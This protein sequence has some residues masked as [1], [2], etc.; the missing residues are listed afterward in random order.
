[1]RAERP[2]LWRTDG[3]NGRA[4]FRLIGSL[5]VL[6]AAALLAVLWHVWLVP[7]VSAALY[8]G[9][10]GPPSVDASPPTVPTV[11]A[12]PKIPV[13]HCGPTGQDCALALLGMV[14]ADRAKHNVPPLQLNRMQS[15]GTSS[16]VGSYGHSAAMARSGS[17]WHIDPHYPRASFPQDICVHS[18]TLGE[19]VGVS[20]SG[21]VLRDL[22]VLDGAMMHE[23]HSAA[24]CAAT[25][26]H[27]CNILNPAF[28][29]IGIGID[30]AGGATWLTEDFGG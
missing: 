22:Q 7:G 28:R 6:T 12:S 30:E 25:F 26:N 17:I 1:V 16:C 4:S 21:S 10:D 27:S 13:L 2:R 14:N 5:R 19:N 23:P 29:W 8:S 18:G 24:V 9:P 15:A 20:D 3:Q 11:P